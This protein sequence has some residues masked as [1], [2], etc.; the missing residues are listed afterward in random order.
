V[1]N[2]ENNEKSSQEQKLLPISSSSPPQFPPDQENLFREVLQLLSDQGVPF[3]VSGAFALQTHT[4]IYRDTKDLDLFLSTEDAQRAIQVLQD[5]GFQCEVSDPV[6]LAKAHR[7]EFFVDLITGMSNGVVQVDRSWID[8]ATP[9][10]LFGVPVRVLGPEE[11]I[12]SK[13]FVTRRERFDGAD[14]VHVIYGTH[15]QLDWDWLLQSVAEHWEVLYWMLLLFHY[16]Y[17]AKVDYVPSRIWDDLMNRFQTAIRNPDR[18]APF[19]GSLIDPLMFAIDV[20][21]WGMP[22]MNQEY[23]ERRQPKLQSSCEEPAA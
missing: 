22:D 13:L 12:L 9:F 14:I 15:G 10:E 7:G 17:P 18:N 19:R 5:D 6:W 2:A 11:L 23:R 1:Q 3:V 21:E 16:A 8:R 20:D 4:G